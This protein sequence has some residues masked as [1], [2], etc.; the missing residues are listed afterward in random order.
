MSAESAGR[1]GLVLK[2]SDCGVLRELYDGSVLT[3]VEEYGGVKKKAS[4][5]L[6]R[7]EKWRLA[8]FLGR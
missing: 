5:P 2:R 7:K 4:Y 8:E 1:N 6:S 3:V